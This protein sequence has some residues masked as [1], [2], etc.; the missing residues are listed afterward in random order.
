VICDRG[1]GALVPPV[2][3]CVYGGGERLKHLHGFGEVFLGEDWVGVDN[4]LHSLNL[5]N[6]LFRGG[7]GEADRRVV[8]IRSIN[9]FMMWD[10]INPSTKDE[11]GSV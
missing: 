10:K 3:V 7:V 1:R 2:C 8:R 6:N 9:A 4:V 11:C 5:R